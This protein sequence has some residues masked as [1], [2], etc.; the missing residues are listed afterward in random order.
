MQ[1]PR[2]IRCNG[3]SSLLRSP[4]SLFAPSSFQLPFVPR[5]AS[6]FSFSPGPPGSN[7]YGWNQVRIRVQVWRPSFVSRVWK[8]DRSK[9]SAVARSIKR[10]RRVQY[11][12]KVVL[13]IEM[14]TILGKF[15]PAAFLFLFSCFSVQNV[16]K[17]WV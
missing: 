5:C 10:G 12:T 3:V 16:R 8:F 2:R 4:R 15:I 14:N 7:D 1:I 17:I 11:R 9:I 13:E 6:L